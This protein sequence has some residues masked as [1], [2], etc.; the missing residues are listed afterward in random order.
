[1]TDAE[2]ASD[3][4]DA[5]RE[6]RPNPIRFIRIVLETVRKE[7]RERCALIAS[8]HATGCEAVLLDC[9]LNPLR[10]AGE[11]QLLRYA[12]D[13]ATDIANAIRKDAVLGGS[14]I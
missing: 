8:T 11:A 2:R 7:E 1:M 6:G 9:V 10:A 13:A 4:Y 5:L 12:R 3:L 14:P